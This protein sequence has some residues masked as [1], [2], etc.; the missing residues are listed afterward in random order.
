MNGTHLSIYGI[1]D[2]VLAPPQTSTKILIY[3]G[4]LTKQYGRWTWRSLRRLW[5][6]SVLKQWIGTCLIHWA[7]SSALFWWTRDSLVAL[8][9]EYNEGSRTGGIVGANMMDTRIRQH[10]I[11]NPLNLMGKSEYDTTVK[12][13]SKLSSDIWVVNWSLK[14]ITRIIFHIASN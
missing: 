5:W 4:K 6:Y 9:N 7:V 10:L 8:Q 13:P 3:D 2:F 12:R 1:R 11:L 14:V